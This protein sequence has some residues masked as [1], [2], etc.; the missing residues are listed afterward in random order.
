MAVVQRRALRTQFEREN[1]T[2]STNGKLE[3]IDAKALPRQPL[4]NSY[5]Q[6]Q[7]RNRTLAPL[8]SNNGVANSEKS[9]SSVTSSLDSG[10][11]VN[12]TN[13]NKL[14]LSPLDQPSKRRNSDNSGFHPNNPSAIYG[15]SVV[16]ESAV[17]ANPVN[18]ILLQ[19]GKAV[20]EL[21]DPDAIYDI[22]TV[23]WIYIPNADK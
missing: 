14:Q 10:H 3:P 21:S 17:P 1:L 8:Q 15:H 20:H 5:V 19:I 22:S 7:N 4:G 16:N 6:V 11:S 13:R 2:K 18:T 23:C 12:P 9:L